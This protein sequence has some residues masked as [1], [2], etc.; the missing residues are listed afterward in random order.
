[1]PSTSGW[2]LRPPTDLATGRCPGFYALDVGLGFATTPPTSS[3]RRSPAVSM[4]SVSGWGLRPGHGRLPG[5][6]AHRGSM[7]SVS[8]WGLRPAPPVRARRPRRVSMPSVSGWG[9]RP[10]HSAGY[11]YFWIGFLCPRCRAGVCDHGEQLIEVRPP[12]CFYALGVGL[13]FATIVVGSAS[14]ATGFYA[15]GVGLGFATNVI[16]IGAV[17]FCFYAL[18]VGLGFATVGLGIGIPTYSAYRF[19]CP[20]CR[21]G[22]CDTGAPATPRCRRR[23]LCPRCRAGVCDY[24]WTRA[25]S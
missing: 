3:V 22:V 9:L 17:L 11:D 10:P 8:G 25:A 21:A 24:T 7:P 18:G 2:G 4:P 13:G 14:A 5:L 19:L 12:T 20:R 6:R 15:L 23:F 16:A 1:M